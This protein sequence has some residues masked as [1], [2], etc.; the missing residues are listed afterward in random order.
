MFLYRK[1]TTTSSERLEGLCESRNS[2][3][4]KDISTS[5][6]WQ[7]SHKATSKEAKKTNFPKNPTLSTF[8]RHGVS[9]YEEFIQSLK[10]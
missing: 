3:L 5:G 9:N 4:E 10:W 7:S 6:V 2:W 8:S 1:I